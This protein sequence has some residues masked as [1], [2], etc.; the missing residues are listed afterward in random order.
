MFVTLLLDFHLKKEEEESCSTTRTLLTNFRA[1]RGE[2][3]LSKSKFSLIFFMPFR[4][5]EAVHNIYLHSASAS[6]MLLCE[7][8]LKKC[9]IKK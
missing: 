1:H 9:L 6:A 2:A 5:L 4:S 3:A 7:N 8:A